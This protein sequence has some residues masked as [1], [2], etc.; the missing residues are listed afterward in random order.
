MCRVH[1]KN[2][3]YSPSSRPRLLRTQRTQPWDERKA[4]AG[5]DCHDGPIILTEPCRNAREARLRDDGRKHN[6]LSVSGERDAGIVP[7]ERSIIRLDAE[8][9]AAR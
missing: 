9:V 6:T 4:L 5:I 2:P 7:A 3:F 8:P 1:R